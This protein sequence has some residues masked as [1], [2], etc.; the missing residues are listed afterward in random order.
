MNNIEKNKHFD[1]HIV[2]VFLEI[3][4]TFIISEN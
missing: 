2:D 4:E 3:N 1:P